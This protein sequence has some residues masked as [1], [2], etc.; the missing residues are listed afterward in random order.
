MG[1][2]CQQSLYRRRSDMGCPVPFHAKLS[3]IRMKSLIIEPP[4][5]G[6]NG[7]CGG[8]WWAINELDKGPSR[9]TGPTICWV[10]LN[11]WLWDV[12]YPFVLTR[13]NLERSF[14]SPFLRVGI[15]CKCLSWLIIVRGTWESL[16]YYK[17]SL[18]TLAL[19]QG[20]VT[21]MI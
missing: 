11:Y 16:A 19:M 7:S 9:Y 10:G 12:Y 21:R 17:S 18:I 2:P 6:K 1:L 13:G 4:K 15:K 8:I 5:S 20:I 3:P 14:K